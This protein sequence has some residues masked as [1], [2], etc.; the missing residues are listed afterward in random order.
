MLEKYFKSASEKF[1]IPFIR[2][3]INLGIKPNVLSFAG[4]LTVIIGCYLFLNNIKTTGALIIFIGSAIDGLDGPL[5]RETNMISKKGALL[6]SFIDR[7]G[8]L[9]IWSVVAIKFTSTDLQMFVILSVI[10]GSSLIPYLRA[11]A[12]SLGIDNK[13][14]LAARPERVIFAVIFMLY[15]LPF[16]SIYIFTFILWLTVYQRFNIL[17][18]NLK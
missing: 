9:F 14:G 17:Y 10:T 8:E 1:A 6:D 11:R 15:E 18:K 13:V 4:L 3:C 7:I 5:A 2:I 16:Y 12:E